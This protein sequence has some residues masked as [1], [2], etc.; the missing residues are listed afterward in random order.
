MARAHRLVLV[1]LCATGVL[2]GCAPA[3]QV[4]RSSAAS[5]PHVQ[6]LSVDGLT[7]VQGLDDLHPRFAWQASS[8]R[9][10]A[11][12]AAYQ[13]RVFRGAGA[14]QATAWDS[15]VVLSPRQIGV[16]YA[17][18]ALQPMAIY[19]WQ[20]RIRDDAGT[21]SAW[22]APATFEMGLGA[23]TSWPARWIEGARGLSSL[24]L[25][26]RE[27]S[28]SQP[29]VRARLYATALGVYAF[30][31]NGHAVGDRHLAPGWT[32]YHKR[33]DY[34]VYDVTD[35]VQVGDNTLAAM[36]A[37]G[38]YAGH[39]GMFGPHKY[40]TEP[41]LR[42]RLRLDFADGSHR[43]IETDGQWRSHA[44]PYVSA[45]LIM[46]ENYDAR[47]LPPGWD[48]AGAPDAG[49]VPVRVVD[50]P[51]I[52][53]QAQAD[54]PVRTTDM[55]VAKRLARQPTPHAT[56]YDMGQNMVGV[57]SLRM[58]GRA[59]QT[60]RIR[61][62]EVLNPDGSLYTKNL[63]TAKATD[64][65]TFA[66]D[67]TVTYTPRFTFHGFR[68]VEISGLSQPLPAEDVHAQVWG[69]DLPQTGQLTTSSPMLNQLLSNIRWGQRGNF[70]SIPTDTP[71]RDER[72]GWTGDI[73]V[74][75]PTA[76]V[77]ADT[78]T[79]LAKWLRDM[80]DAQGADGDYPSVAPD[81]QHI[82]GASGWSDAGITVPYALWQAYGDTR[83]IEDGYAS[84]RR[85]MDFIEAMSGP[86]LKRVHGG[87]GDW[88][89]LDDPTPA[90][91]IGTAYVAYDARL[92]A[93]MAR[94]IGKSDDARHYADLAER[95]RAAFDQ[96]YIADGRS[97]SDSQTSYAL[98]L[99]MQLVPPTQVAPLADRLAE[100]VHARHD[101]LATGFLGT[102]WLLDAL[103]RGGHAKLAYTLLMNTDYPSWGY[104]VKSGA[105]TMWERWNSLK[106]D[107]SF[108]DPSM[109]S[110][111]HY[112]YGAVG[113]W[114]FRHIGGIA[115][116]KPG[117]EDVRIAPLPGGG[118]TS[119][120][121]HLDGPYGEIRS[122]W[123]LADGH[124]TG[125]FAVPFNSRASVTLP[126]RSIDAVMLEGHPLSSVPGVSS[127]GV[128]ASGVHFDI[129]S[130]QWTYRITGGVSAP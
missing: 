56:L 11:T 84:M 114:M 113:D 99:G 69:S 104:E 26:R 80:R 5:A 41:A 65:Y 115:P 105:T 124:M 94:A 24:P 37:P 38:W 25:L 8:A 22:S 70:L 110:F 72:L 66:T 103:T 21:W 79:F 45:D 48:R 47:R 13:V 16:A 57:A 55:R 90:D 127:L 9:R 29:V 102:P 14:S 30:H 118:L 68:Y 40:G 86:S 12:Q 42:A 49:W 121:M 52:A 125:S 23:A 130:G 122:S 109:N 119:A 78:D 126:A 58:S 10:D 43:W 7:Q 20:V 107:G 83:V 1:A 88:L 17:G 2:S 76:S 108:G 128:D 64:D 116:G 85:F 67:G 28:L 97:T 96:R 6:E 60:V 18:P 59:G 111:N 120:R 92:M 35:Q 74:F 82:D 75:A 123:S 129:G 87:Y 93:D 19:R 27:F 33:A 44:G 62:G 54:P 4:H 81:P 3:S 91:V 63:R 32:D 71:A 31:L 112:A 50:P 117:Y 39:V 101:H 89:N 36:I 106:P 98:A 15:G 53:L 73:N 34:Q 100:R 61:Y 51:A 46:G 95:A 77:L